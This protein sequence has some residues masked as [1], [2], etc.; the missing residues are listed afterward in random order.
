MTPAQKRRA[1]RQSLQAAIAA[2]DRYF[3]VHGLN[4]DK[5]A[6][7]AGKT[8]GDAQSKVWTALDRLLDPEWA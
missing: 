3:Q 4:A 7:L 6:R 1:S 2:L 5:A 8:V